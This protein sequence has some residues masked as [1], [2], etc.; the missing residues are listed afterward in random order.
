MSV[1]MFAFSIMRLLSIQLL[2][3]IDSQ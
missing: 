2:K 3:D 1:M